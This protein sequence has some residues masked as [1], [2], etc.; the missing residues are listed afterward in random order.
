MNIEFEKLGTDKVVIRLDDFED[1]LDALAYDSASGRSDET[2]PAEVVEQLLAGENAMRVY[3]S[4]RNMTQA[5][6]A[7]QVG[8]SQAAIAEIESGRKNGSMASL[9]KIA[10]ALNVDID[11][12]V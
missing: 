12:L 5:A 11:D 7:S 6:L 10:K 8:L 3:R 4:Y 9:K 1:M 2:F